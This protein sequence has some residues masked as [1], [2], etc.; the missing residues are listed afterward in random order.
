M[1]RS[2]LI[3][4]FGGESRQASEQPRVA[5]LGTHPEP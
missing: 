3:Q 5:R 1:M 4:F 2:H